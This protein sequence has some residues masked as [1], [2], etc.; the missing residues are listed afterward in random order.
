M[1]ILS[2]DESPRSPRRGSSKKFFVVAT[3]AT[4]GF[5]GST[6]AASVSLNGGGDMEFGQ[7]VS[8]AV[9][10]ASSLLVIPT[11]S[12]NGSS[13]N[14]ETITVLDSVTVATDSANIDTGT[15]RNC[16]GKKISI[17]A[18]KSDNSP[19]WACD[20]ALNS[21]TSSSGVIVGAGPLGCSN[22]DTAT[23]TGSASNR[24]FAIRYNTTPKL[25]AAEVARIT[26]ES[27]N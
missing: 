3:I 1:E 16:I 6:F 15:I 24:G 26:L 23:A 7:G 14:L 20:V 10:C 25:A 4:L 18:L 11:N 19:L 12:Y 9:G 17:K 27:H 8:T 13:F 5:F 22:L 2:F 21:Y